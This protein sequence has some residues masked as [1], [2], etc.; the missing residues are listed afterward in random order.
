[1]PINDLTF[2]IFGRISS[3]G[4]NY[5]TICTSTKTY[6]KVF[7][8]FTYTILCKNCHILVTNIFYSSS[9][10]FIVLY[11]SRIKPP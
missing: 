5:I 9:P 3:T 4:N 7:F 8:F 6:S 1:M 2:T 11:V 10:N